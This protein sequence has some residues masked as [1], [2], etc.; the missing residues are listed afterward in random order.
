M[1]SPSRL[2]SLR[3]VAGVIATTAL[4][5]GALAL[6]R[7]AGNDR[8]PTPPAT[9]AP[10]VVTTVAPSTTTPRS[11]P[12]H[13]VGVPNVVGLTRADALVALEDAGFA[14]HVDS[15][16]LGSVPDGFVVSQSPLPSA[17]LRKGSTVALVVSAAP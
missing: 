5:L 11:A 2:V 16:A 1:N 7:G 6:V 3:V 8:P 9:T 10:A 17:Q 14:V 15:M 13:T 4:A 12:V